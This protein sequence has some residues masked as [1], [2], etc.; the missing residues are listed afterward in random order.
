MK[1]WHEVISTRALFTHLENFNHGFPAKNAPK[2]FQTTLE[3]GSGLGEHLEYENLT[4][5]QK[6]DYTAV[7]LRENMA[8]AIKAKYPEINTIVGDCQK[9]LPF[10]DDYFDRILAIHVLEHLPNLPATIKE[11]HRLCNKERGVFSVVI[12]C[13]G[14]MLYS[15]LRRFSS[16]RMFEKRYKQP[17]SW[18]I[19]REH[20]NMPEE[21][22]QELSH[23][24]TIK[25]RRFFPFVLPSV[26][27]N[28]V[29][30]L[31]LVPK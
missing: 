8:D 2:Q 31:T 17:Y 14:G 18:F 5:Q 28:L 6:S 15:L 25:K 1:H 16:K 29:I 20:I 7:E 27:T 30:G 22:I 23:Y 24:F 12:P 4:P 13:E 9:E 11:M 10:A 3:I 26:N 19:S 21:I